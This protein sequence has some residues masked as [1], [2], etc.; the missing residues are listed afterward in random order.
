MTRDQDIIDHTKTK[1][2]KILKTILI[3]VGMNLTSF[4][5]TY[6]MP[7]ENEP[8]E[9][10]WLQWPHQYEYGL[11]YRNSIDAT[12][13]A[14][15]Q[16]LV[17]GEKVHIIAYDNTE[18]NRIISLLTAA[19]IPLTNV[20]FF[21]FQTN[22]VWIRDNGPIFVRDSNGNLLI[23]DWGFN[24]WGGKFNF[25]LCDPIPDSIG[26]T[27]TMPVIDL[28]SIMV[29]EGGA[30]ELDGNGVLMACKSSIISQSPP[31][32]VRNP[33]MTQSQ[34]ETI[35][36]Q[37]LGVTKFIWLDGNVGDPN[38]VTDFHI[39]GFAKFL[40]D[41]TLVTMNNAD[42]TYW[43]A[44]AS[45]IATLYGASNANSIVYTKVYLPLTQNNVVTTSGNNL[46]YKGS[47]VNYYVANDVVLVPN[48]NDPNDIVANGIIQSLY[49]NK[50]VVG[51]DCR[52]LYEWGGM[53]HCVTQQQ[54]VSSTSGL[55]DNIKTEIK[56][57]MNF[58][59]PFSQTTTINITLKNVTD[60]NVT[61]YSSICQIVSQQDNSNL[62]PGNHSLIISADNLPNGVYTY[63]VTVGD[64][65]YF[66]G[67]M[68]ILKH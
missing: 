11:A 3:L 53:V 43:G 56:V 40:N 47:Y 29:N 33:G 30:V 2:M 63:V 60:V 4:G 22:D 21:I 51:V 52:N 17:G 6:Q 13:V 57:G 25:N 46:G 19:S 35:F 38:D 34:A 31:N 9:G 1:K 18:M 42:L 26:T 12:W 8:H 10:T 5:Q 50:T 44:S 58:P 62:S 64:Q 36:T 39:D 41:D 24:G 37:Y 45:D 7:N 54:P 27:I 65:N 55:N 20:D 59:N 49:P 32:S 61:I 16:A 23:E 48:Y 68:V 67:R 66:N 28:N 14:M 15:T